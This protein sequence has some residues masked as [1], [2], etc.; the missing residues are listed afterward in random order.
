MIRSVN[1]LHSSGKKQAIALLSEVASP[2]LGP[3]IVTDD[4]GHPIDPHQLERSPHDQTVCT[5]VPLLFDIPE[6]GTPPPDAWYSKRHR[7]WQ[8]AAAGT[9]VVQGGIPFAVTG[10]W[11]YAGCPYGTRPLVEWAAKHGKLRAKQ[12]H[13]QDDPLQA[14]DALCDRIRTGVVGEFET[15]W[16][17]PVGSK[18]DRLV[19]QT[20]DDL[21]DQAMKM[22]HN[23]MRDIKVLPW[24]ELRQTVSRLGVR[25]DLKTEMHVLNDSQNGP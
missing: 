20:Q 8:G 7:C 25:W 5:I 16:N 22:L 21:R 17:H 4:E 11:T 18:R 6:K 10:E 23:G 24:D 1:C 12:L 9:Q 13:P 15:S 2:E 19:D 14:A 3:T